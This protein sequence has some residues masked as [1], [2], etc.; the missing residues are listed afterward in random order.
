[1]SPGPSS[2]ANAP[3]PAGEAALEPKQAAVGCAVSPAGPSFL[4]RDP[5]LDASNPEQMDSSSKLGLGRTFFKVWAG[6]GSRLLVFARGLPRDTPRHPRQPEQ[7]QH[8]ETADTPGPETLLGRQLQGF[9]GIQNLQGR[10]KASRALRGL[11]PLV[12][13]TQ[14]WVSRSS[15]RVTCLEPDLD[16]NLAPAWSRQVH[17]VQGFRAS[18][19]ASSH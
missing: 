6:S 4:P 9:Q 17:L 11:L 12:P 15:V 3:K 8:P 18:G 16:P 14:K 7:A 2:R 5:C 13:K 19:K 10:P 1:M